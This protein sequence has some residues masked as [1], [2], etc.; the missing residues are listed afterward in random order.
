M[1]EKN[2]ESCKKPKADHEESM[3]HTLDLHMEHKVN[4]EFTK[5]IHRKREQEVFVLRAGE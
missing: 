3:K 5:K 1:Q 2:K 4:E